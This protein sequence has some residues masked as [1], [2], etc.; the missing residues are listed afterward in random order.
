MSPRERLLPDIV[1]INASSLELWR[2]C[3]RE[4]LNKNV[5]GVPES[6]SGASPDFGNLVHAM[7]EQIHRNGSCRDT[8]HVAEV[9][10]LHG[11][12]ADDAMTGIVARHAT[13]CPSPAEHSKHE[14]ELARFHR[15]PPP[16]FMAT[17]RLDAVWQHDGLLDI[18]DYKTGGVTTERIVDDPR[19]RLQVWL[20]QPIADRLGLRLRIR[21]EHLAAEV[22]DDPEPFEPDEEDLEAIDEELRTTAAA[23]QAAAADHD[24]PGVADVEVCGYCR[25]RSIC[26]ASAAPGVPT[27]PTP[28]DPDL[29]DDDLDL[30]L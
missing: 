14:L 25:Y 29:D 16:M 28:P 3:R 12:E 10:A 22:G 18:R 21:Y 23:M 2:R 4:Y 1:P 6:D 8:E 15:L 7:L 24:F 17:G 26:P 5:L 19:A 11:I 20:A 13:R 27:W 9:L 30:D